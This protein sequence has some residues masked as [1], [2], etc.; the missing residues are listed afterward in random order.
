MSFVLPALELLRQMLTLVIQCRNTDFQDL[1]AINAIL[2]TYTLLHAF[3]SS[4]FAYPAAQQG[5]REVIET[6]LAYTQPVQPA[7]SSEKEGLNNSLWTLMMAEVL[8]Y[9][10]T[11]AHTFMSG[12]LLLSE[13]LPLPLPVQ[14]RSPLPSDEIAQTMTSRRLWCAHLHS[15]SSTIGDL[16]STL[17]GSSCPSLLQLLRR[18]C[19]QLSDLAAPTALVVVRSILDAILVS[20]NIHPKAP[21]ASLQPEG[22][23]SSHT[24]RLLNF[25]A[26]LIT[27]ASVKCATLNLLCAGARGSGVKAD[28]RFP[29]LISALCRI[30][31]T[32]YDKPPHIQAQECVVSVIQSLCDVDI[33]LLP[34]PG[35]GVDSTASSQQFLASALPPREILA[36]FCAVLLEHVT[37]LQHSFTTLLPT[38][39]TFLMLAEHDYGFYHLKSKDS[40]DLLST[41]S[42]LLEL[43]RVCILPEGEYSDT[44]ISSS[45]SKMVAKLFNSPHHAVQT[46]N[47]DHIKDEPEAMDVD[48]PLVNNDTEQSSMSINSNNHSVK[49]EPMDDLV[50]RKKTSMN[51]DQVLEQTIPTEFQTP[52]PNHQPQQPI[53][54]KALNND[55]ESQ[56]TGGLPARKL[57]LSVSELSTVIGWHRS[58]LPHPLADAE[59]SESSSKRHPILLL[60]KLLRDC[61]AEEESLESLHESVSGL[62]R[63]LDDEDN[64]PTEHKASDVGEVT[65]PP[66][67]S[68][69]TQFSL[70]PVFTICESDDDRL[71]LGYWLSV[72]TSD[73]GDQDTEQV[74]CDLL[75]FS[76]EHIPDLHL[77][78][79]SVRL[80]RLRAGLGEDVDVERSD[81]EN[82]KKRVTGDDVKYLSSDLKTRR[83][84]VTPM[85]G[86]GFSRPVP[87]RGDLFRSR[88]PNTSRPP[89]LH[90]DDF[91]ALETCGAQPTGPTGYN[92]MSMRAAKDM[93]AT[94]SRGR[95][96][97]FGSERGRF[98]GSGHQYRREGGLR[99]SN[100]RG[101]GP[102]SWVPHE[103]PGQM[104]GI[105]PQRQFRAIDQGRDGRVMREEKFGSSLAGRLGSIRGLNWP[106]GKEG[107]RFNRGPG[108]MGRGGGGN[109]RRDSGRHQ[110]TFTR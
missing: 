87:Q 33:S 24:A 93:M 70:R 8:K 103:N 52:L 10:T 104:A 13:L 100:I 19:V 105:G 89:S 49:E 29:P 110:R 101:D 57:A 37:I 5:C 91:V 23:C 55:L 1:T 68:L 7:S 84:F 67:E 99:A 85:R 92:K 6:L 41:L 30:L 77:L 79:E 90:V 44:D 47:S 74:A 98:F 4:A 32:P 20:L 82:S 86:R 3:P 69:L 45:R 11:N 34:P 22:P 36:T 61:S 25:L 71:S 80:C 63:I 40:A 50:S 17:C 88:P 12:L 96:R 9:I 53:P 59:N 14:T 60:E 27:H 56:S 43:L 62:L 64:L 75:D 48:V 58:D 106:G 78:A 109:S 107:D 35:T 39:R 94:R 38:V 26:C 97:G 42:T 73:E 72:P 18:V 46:K 83:P 51:A 31:R 28:E 102:N 66:P 54:T 21:P 76:R 95:G 16:I 108:P 81:V 15:L 2:Q 65:L